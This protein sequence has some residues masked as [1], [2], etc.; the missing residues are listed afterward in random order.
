M[1]VDSEMQIAK[2]AVLQILEKRASRDKLAAELV[3]YEKFIRAYKILPPE[4][5]DERENRLIRCG[6]EENEDKTLI[7]RFYVHLLRQLN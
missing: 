2:A 6:G 3:A 1:C 7:G 4:A 5:R